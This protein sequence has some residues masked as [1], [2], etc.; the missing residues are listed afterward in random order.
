MSFAA[1]KEAVESLGREQVGNIVTLQYITDQS[2]LLEYLTALMSSFFGSLVLLLAGVGLFGVDV[3]RGGATA[4]RDW[5]S[6]GARRRPPPPRTG[7]HLRRLDGHTGWSCRRRRHGARHRTGRQAVAL[8]CDTSGSVDAG[9]GGGIPDR[10]RDSGVYCP[11]VEG[12]A[13]RPNDRTPTRIA[14]IT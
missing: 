12:G 2:L 9:R 8:W 13:C 7:R 1:L 3:V 4:T 14:R 11:G 5:Y 10:D 6:H